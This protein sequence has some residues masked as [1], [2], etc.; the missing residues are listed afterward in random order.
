MQAA[1]RAFEGAYAAGLLWQ[2]EPRAAVAHTAVDL[3]DSIQLSITY[4]SVTAT[5]DC[6]DQLKV[7]VSVTLT[8]SASG[9]ADSGDA[10]LAIQRWSEGL[11]GTLHYE[12]KLVRLDATLREIA[13]GSAPLASFD[14]LDPQLPGASANFTEAP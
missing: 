2:V 9:L 13:A 11:V 10:T 12:S 6:V 3:R 14:A 4:G 7:P 8:T 5:R 1:A